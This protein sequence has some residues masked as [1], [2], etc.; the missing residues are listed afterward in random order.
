MADESKKDIDPVIAHVKKT[1]A[2]L[3]RQLKGDEKQLAGDE[4]S[5]KAEA[6][7]K[8]AM[9][10][11]LN[12]TRL[13]VKGEKYQEAKGMTEI[14]EAVDKTNDILKKLFGHINDKT[15]EQVEQIV[16]GN[17]LEESASATTDKILATNEL[18]KKAYDVQNKDNKEAKEPDSVKVEKGKKDA[19]IQKSESNERKGIIDSIKNMKLGVVSKIG[20]S[21]LVLYLVLKAIQFFR[22]VA[23]VF[24]K[25]ATEIKDCV[26]TTKEF[27][28][29]DIGIGA[30]LVENL[31]V[32]VVS[33]A[34]LFK[35]QI[36][37]WLKTAFTSFIS[38]AK[39][40]W[41]PLLAVLG[42]PLVAFAAF[43]AG[44]IALV[45]VFT[46]FFDGWNTEAEK[47]ANFIHK[48][49]GALKGAA[50][51][52]VETFDIIIGEPMR[53]LTDMLKWLLSFLPA[54]LSLPKRTQQQVNIDNKKSL[55]D[56]NDFFGNLFGSKDKV[57]TA[58]DIGPAGKGRGANIT[59]NIIQSSNNL[60]NTSSN[61]QIYASSVTDG[62]F[63][64][65]T[66][67]T[68]M[69]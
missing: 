18:M 8:A 67:S 26:K 51:G 50:L 55:D 28:S 68:S 46:G 29:G 41:R 2:L 33:L 39:L 15:A 24:A 6:L 16:K 36:W 35:V 49:L 9:P 19:V 13:Q 59:N 25:V 57:I 64:G 58:A 3:E 47:G 38:F 54:S 61:T 43:F 62:R 1:N 66:S 17:K 53:M 4:A 63:V 37:I 7:I 44:A 31:D 45:K 23:K 21:I 56:I 34:Y 10:E 12:D 42:A 5:G 27:F 14:D 40:A 69:G 65:T 22:P 32:F 20:A 30:W 60:D 11:M 52:L 48:L